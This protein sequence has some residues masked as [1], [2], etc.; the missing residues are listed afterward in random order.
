MFLPFYILL[1]FTSQMF[2]VPFLDAFPLS[3]H[4]WIIEIS[5]FINLE[6]LQI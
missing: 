5:T 2:G 4:P 3:I 6:D 1:H